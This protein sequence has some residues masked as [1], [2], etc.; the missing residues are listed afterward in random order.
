MSKKIHRDDSISE[1]KK[2]SLSKKSKRTQHS[3]SGKCKISIEKLSHAL[4]HHEIKC[5]SNKVVLYDEFESERHDIEGSM[6]SRYL[7]METDGECLRRCQKI[8]NLQNRQ[9]SASKKRCKEEGQRRLRDTRA[10]RKENKKQ[11]NFRMMECD[12]SFNLTPLISVKDS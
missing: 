5:K 7:P 3:N 12:D 9:A 2:S 11:M 10:R 1:S 8:E 6:T 4:Y